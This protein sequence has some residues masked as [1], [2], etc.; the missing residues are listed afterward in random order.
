MN[1][2]QYPNY[3]FEV[4]LSDK[5]ADN[6]VLDNLDITSNYTENKMNVKVT[7]KNDFNI[8]YIKVLVVYYQNDTIIDCETGITNSKTGPNKTA[9]INVN[10]PEDSNYNSFD[11]YEVYLIDTNINLYT[12]N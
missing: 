5:Y 12:T 6:I 3:E 4:E 11:N 1:F 10:Y 7:N 8:D 2:V 9:S